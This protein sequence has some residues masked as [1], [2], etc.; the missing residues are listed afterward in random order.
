MLGQRGKLKRIALNSKQS[1][2]LCG[3]AA[4]RAESLRLSGVA[5][6]ISA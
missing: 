6:F 3:S 2:W 5:S 4:F 1:N